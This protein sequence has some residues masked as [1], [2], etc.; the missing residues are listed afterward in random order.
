M[1]IQTTKD[2]LKFWIYVSR[3]LL[4]VC[5]SFLVIIRLLTKYIAFSEQSYQAPNF[6]NLD[7][8]VMGKILSSDNLN[9]NNEMII[10]DA[11]EYWLSCN[12]LSPRYYLHFSLFILCYFFV[13]LL[14]YFK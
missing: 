2:L 8:N 13:S 7:A 14:I 4:L 12:S 10:V 5:F 3:A 11:L 1:Q 9:V 6:C